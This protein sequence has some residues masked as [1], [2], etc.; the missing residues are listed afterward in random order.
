MKNKFFT[1]FSSTKGVRGK[2]RGAFYILDEGRIELVPNEMIIIAEL[3]QNFSI[4]EC[5]QKVDSEDVLEEYLNFM[6]EKKIGFFT[7][8]PERFATIDNIYEV[9]SR[10][11]I[12]N[13]E[14]SQ[15]SQ[16]DLR[17]FIQEL[18]DNLC[19]HVEL[20]LYFE[21]IETDDLE[22]IFRYFDGTTIRSINVYLS[23]Y[24]NEDLNQLRNLLKKY[25]K[26][27]SF[28]IFSQVME[29]REA[30][31][32][33]KSSNIED[34]DRKPYSKDVLQINHHY[35]T[36][37]QNNNPFYFKKVSIDRVGFLKN[38]LIDKANYGLYKSGNN[39][40]TRLTKN[41]T[42]TRFWYVKPDL[43]ENIKDSELRY[44]MFL[45]NELIEDNGKYYF[46]NNK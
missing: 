7:S 29:R 14:Y 27:S 21:S 23:R 8:Q 41:P 13:I 17:S 35:Y 33:F 11:F 19:K 44:A 45:T 3:L 31:I 4:Y 15:N 5:A 9:P 2:H 20:R 34:F 40:L 22:R 42:F 24:S 32:S 36:Q 18:S 39:V 38:N 12:S 30:S 37:C 28:I 43:I 26:I 16:Y 25:R 6:V 46:A 10:I 1:L